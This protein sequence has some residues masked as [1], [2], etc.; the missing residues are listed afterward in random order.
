MGCHKPLI[1]DLFKVEEKGNGV[2]QA[3]MA[4]LGFADG[5]ELFGALLK[6]KT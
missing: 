3:G 5:G 2:P 6:F 1:W 4:W